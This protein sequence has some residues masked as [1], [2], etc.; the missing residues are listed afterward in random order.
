M[1]RAWNIFGMIVLALILIIEE[2]VYQF[3]DD[4]GGVS[5]FPV[6]RTI[7]SEITNE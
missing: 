5:F 3:Y 2:G 6:S 7:I 1:D 4:E